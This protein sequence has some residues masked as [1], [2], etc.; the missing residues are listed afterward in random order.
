[1]KLYYSP[2][3]SSLPAH[4]ALREAGL[5]FDLVRVNLKTRQTAA[6]ADFTAVNPKG[7]VPALQLE[8]G[9][10]LTEGAAILQYLGELA[11][12]SG[13]L[14]RAGTMERQRVVEWLA[15]IATEL[16]KNYSP[17]FNP[18]ASA[19]LKQSVRP[20]IERRL[21]YVESRLGSGPFLMGAQF[22]A[23]DCYLFTVLRWSQY[24]EIDLGRWPALRSYVDRVA[25]RPSVQA[26][27]REEGL[28]K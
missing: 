23:A 12:A 3:S 2:G 28:I 7:Y 13:L 26:A 11:P 24:V 16:H 9:E 25:A 17:L 18:A 5:P 1:M 27:M 6:G 10:V 20:L 22:C 14:P 8:S 19:E 21:A 4:I 15:F